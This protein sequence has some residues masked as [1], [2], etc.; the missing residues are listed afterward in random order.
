[1]TY[2]DEQKMW[3]RIHLVQRLAD[4]AIILAFVALLG[5]WAIVLWFGR[6]R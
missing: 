5:A 2:R 6:L 1:M 4:M 3:R